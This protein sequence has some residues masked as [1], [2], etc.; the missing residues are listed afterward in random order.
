MNEA[1]LKASFLLL[2]SL[3]FMIININPKEAIIKLAK[4]YGS[5]K[6]KTTDK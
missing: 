6:N 3:G 5:K 4:L 1:M 2:F